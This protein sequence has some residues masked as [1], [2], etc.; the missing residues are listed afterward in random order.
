VFESG[1][2]YTLVQVVD[3]AQ[4]TIEDFDK[5]AERIMAM[6]RHRRGAQ[7]VRD[8][9]DSR[10]EELDKAGKIKPREDKIAEYDQKGNPVPTTYRACN[11]LDQPR[12]VILDDG[13]VYCPELFYCVSLR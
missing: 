10:C 13:R 8:W 6:M 12:E 7:L 4:G 5:N 1:G 2:N 11:T 3:K 9:L